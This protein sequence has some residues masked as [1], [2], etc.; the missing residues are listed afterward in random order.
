MLFSNWYYSNMI[1]MVLNINASL[2]IF[3]SRR[4]VRTR[5]KSNR[6]TGGTTAV[7]HARMERGF[8]VL[9]TLMLEPDGKWQPHGSGMC[10]Q[11]MLS[12][13]TGDFLIQYSIEGCCPVIQDKIMKSQSVT[14][15]PCWMSKM[16]R[17]QN[18]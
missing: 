18:F 11:Q 8:E 17:S 15:M 1:I 5:D 10:F 7:C 9:E 14:L 3:P 6:E 2:S 4:N 12:A 13:K 16:Y